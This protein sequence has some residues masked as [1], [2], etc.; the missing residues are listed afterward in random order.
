MKLLSDIMK[1]RVSL[2]FINTG[3][4][5]IDYFLGNGLPL[6]R[7]I[8]ISGKE[9]SG[10]TTFGLYLM[11]LIQKS[12]G[13]VLYIDSESSLEDIRTKNILDVEK[14]WY[15][16]TNIV[17]DVFKIIVSFIE[18]NLS[19]NVPLGII[20]DSVGY[21][22]TDQEKIDSDK[23]E[24][25][26][27]YDPARRAQKIKQEITRKLKPMMSKNISVIFI[28]QE[29][30]DIGTSWGK[31]YTT[32]GGRF[33]RFAYSIRLRLKRKSA[34]DI[35]ED[36]KRV[37]MITEVVQEKNKI[38]PREG[39]TLY[40]P[41]SFYGNAINDREIIFT[42]AEKF[43]V[44]K[45]SKGEKSLSFLPNEGDKFSVN[46]K[47]FKLKKYKKYEKEIIDKIKENLD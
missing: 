11:S 19:K 45:K 37:G 8:E 5:L 20:W 15:D 10:K 16:D 28:N 32:P 27:G 47:D 21:C 38:A 26:S 42:N 24:D 14:C 12:G 46:K 23:G 25:P 43:G 40:L 1:E 33:L 44:F 31:K 35:V 9:S 3:S 36:G 41:I 7:I 4:E 17:E 13:I 30:D 2:P 22:I 29:Y 34:D 39:R 18:D 6:G